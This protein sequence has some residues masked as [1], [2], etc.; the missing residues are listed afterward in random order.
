[1]S[2]SQRYLKRELGPLQ[3][4]RVSLGLSVDAKPRTN[5]AWALRQAGLGASGIEYLRYSE[6]EQAQRVVALYAG[7]CRTE[8]RASTF[9]YLVMAAQVD[10]QRVWGALLVELSR[11]MDARTT[12]LAC[13]SGPDVIAAASK[14]ARKPDGCQ[15][16]KLLLQAA[17]M[18]AS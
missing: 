5:Y 14:N 9:D 2:S 16:R 3:R 4:C 17:R 10:A 13:M 8:R 7:L 18:I 15:D 11:V 1:M 12:L 6:D